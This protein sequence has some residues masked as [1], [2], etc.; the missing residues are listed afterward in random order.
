MPSPPSPS[1]SSLIFLLHA[2]THPPTPGRITRFEERPSADSLAAMRR[3][4][5]APAHHAFNVNMGIYVFKRAALFKLLD[6]SKA[7]AITHIGYHVIPNALAQVGGGAQ[8]RGVCVC[9]VVWGGGGGCQGGGGAHAG[10]VCVLGGG[11]V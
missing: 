8:A 4:A 10:G 3:P 9:V 7:S 2:P 1:S 5:P 11:G 6:P